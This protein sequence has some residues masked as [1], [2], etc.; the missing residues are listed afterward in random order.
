VPKASEP[1]IVVRLSAKDGER[2]SEAATV[3][4]VGTSTLL[5]EAAMRD[6]RYLETARELGREKAAKTSGG[7]ATVTPPPEDP[8][9]P[10]ASSAEILETIT[11]P[12]THA[13]PVPGC[14]YRAY[15]PSAVCSTHGRRAT[16]PVTP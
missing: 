1:R 13:C 5:R 4:G 3:A 15:V 12:Y 14:D 2:L 6:G 9:P 10:A 11:S 16:L 8:V 7:K